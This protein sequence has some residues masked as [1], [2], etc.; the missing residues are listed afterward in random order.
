MQ[1]SSEMLTVGMSESLDKILVTQELQHNKTKQINPWSPDVRGKKHHSVSVA[2]RTRLFM[3]FLTF[4][5]NV[6]SPYYPE[7]ALRKKVVF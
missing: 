1:R 5:S 6:K 2:K 7:F 4:H 3:L